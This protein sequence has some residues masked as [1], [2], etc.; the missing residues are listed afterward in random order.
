MWRG[1]RRRQISGPSDARPV[2]LALLGVG[3]A[4]VTV[5]GA[6]A[7]VVIVA[8]AWRGAVV[9]A[10]VGAVVG[11]MAVAAVVNEAEDVW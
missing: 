7:V 10:V 4:V 6:E 11:S 8:P 1:H 5:V 2:A 3:A 9:V